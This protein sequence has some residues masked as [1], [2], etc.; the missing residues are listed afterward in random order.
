MIEHERAFRKAFFDMTEKVKVHYEER[1]VRMEGES[2]RN[3]IGKGNPVGEGHGDGK[4]PPSTTPSSSPPSSPSSSSSSTTTTLPYINTHNS[5]SAGKSPLLL[6]DVKFE[7]PM[8]NGEV[9]G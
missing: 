4:K 5:K 7:I 3:P 2:S 8:Y 9:N 6:L 1:N